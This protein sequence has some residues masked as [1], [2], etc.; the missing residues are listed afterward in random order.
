MLFGLMVLAVDFG[1]VLW[2][3]C[4]LPGWGSLCR[5]VVMRPLRVRTCCLVQ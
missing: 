1:S 5:V 4:V 2:T 3:S